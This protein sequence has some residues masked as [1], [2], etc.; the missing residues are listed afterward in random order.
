MKKTKLLA[1]AL[2]L[3][4]PILFSANF[5]LAQTD[6]SAKKPGNKTALA[7]DK[8]NAELQNKKTIGEAAAVSASKT[9]AKTGERPCVT[10]VRKNPNEITQSMLSKMPLDRQAFVK[11]H[12]EKYTIVN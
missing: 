6:A 2:M 7:T 11:S 1:K 10:N 8:K 3:S 4:A 5:L 12:P 9:K